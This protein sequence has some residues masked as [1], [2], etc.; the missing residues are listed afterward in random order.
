[1]YNN[2]EKKLL[3]N[4]INNI[5][6][7]KNI[8][9][10]DENLINENEKESL[11]NTDRSNK[12]NNKDNNNTSL[13]INTNNN[14]DNKSLK[15][16]LSAKNITK[17]YIFKTKSKNIIADMQIMKK[18]ISNDYKS[19]MITKNKSSK[20]LN[21]QLMFTKIKMPKNNKN[22]ATERNNIIVKR[23]NNKRKKTL[24]NKMSLE[25]L[26][27]DYPLKTLPSYKS[28]F[29]RNN[30]LTSSSGIKLPRYNKTMTKNRENIE[31]GLNMPKLISYFFY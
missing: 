29:H 31:K 20:N 8:A 30:T 22:E 23:Q 4:S 7:N 12:N 3:L 13:N 1:M 25:F 24:E 15:L 10:K 9:N 17:K 5:N 16:L 27:N 28:F 6:K 18:E 14:N 21:N 11:C 26:E 19:C 2:K